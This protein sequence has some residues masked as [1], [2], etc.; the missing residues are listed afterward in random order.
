[1]SL[2]AKLV[3]ATG[4]MILLCVLVAAVGF[5]QNR[6]L[7][8]ASSRILEDN[9]RTLV[10]VER[11]RWALRYHNADTLN[12]YLLAEADNIT[13]PG[14]AALVDSLKHYQRLGE[15]AAL[16]PILSQILLLNMQ[17]MQNKDQA[18]QKAAASAYLILGIVSATGLMGLLVFA[19]N[20]PASILSPIRQLTQR[21][22]AIAEGNYNQRYYVEDRYELGA[23]GKAFNRM[24]SELETFRHSNLAE[25]LF[26]KTRFE[27]LLDALRDPLMIVDES[28][29]L[30]FVNHKA[31]EAY[32]G[33]RERS[34]R[35][36]IREAITWNDLLR[37]H[38]QLLESG[39]FASDQVWDVVIGKQTRHYTP[40]GLVVEA[41]DP[42]SNESRVVGYVLRLRDVTEIKE[43]ELAK[44][45]FLATISHELKTPLSAMNLSL[46]LLKQEGL[47]SGQE[48]LVGHLD[49]ETQRMMKLISDLLLLSRLESKADYIQ[50]TPIRFVELIEKLQAQLEIS[51]SEKQIQWSLSVDSNMVCY[52][53]SGKL[54]LALS[55]LLSNAIRYSPRGGTIYFSAWTEPEKLFF[56]IRDQGPGVPAEVIPRLFEKFYSTDGG[57]GLGLAISREI[58]QSLRGDILYKEGAFLA[59]F[60]Q[61]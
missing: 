12:R 26:E 5:Y 59:W 50:I 35:T 15:W 34:L 11:M 32:F 18:S 19:S 60:P 57:H 21:L 36:K 29:Q 44:T 9:Y 38:W 25:V 49:R 55:N 33:Q 51:T 20:F 22:N 41:L 43:L 28:G 52:T 58:L 14:E 2:K 30:A 47:A 1:M 4:S 10:Y 31:Q 7:A 48:E 39:A 54:E 17:A 45:A 40:E 16:E 56:S 42:R 46:K 13:E 23:L 37:Q 27:T 6:Q 8:E 53:D 3:W 24:V 61:R